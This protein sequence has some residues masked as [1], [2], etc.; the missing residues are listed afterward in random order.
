MNT[1]KSIQNFV[2][3]WLVFCWPLYGQATESTPVTPFM[4]ALVVIDIQNVYLPMMDQQEV[5]PAMEAIN[6][7]IDVFRQ[8]NYPVIRVYHHEPGQD[9]GPG[10]EAF[11]FP[12][13]V[14]VTDDDPQVIKN[15]PSAFQKT[16]LDNILKS[17]GVNSLYLCGLSATGCVLATYFGALER[18]YDVVMVKEAI[19]SNKAEYTAMVR[20]I[21][22]AWPL[23]FVRT[24]VSLLSGDMQILQT[25]SNKQ[26]VSK[27][28]IRAAADLNG[29]GY[30][31]IFKNRLA[32]AI[33]VFKANARLFPD[34]AN[35]FDSL[36]DA[37]ERNGQNELA[38]ANY[39]KAF[40]KAKEKNDP[41]LA[42]FEKNYKRLKEANK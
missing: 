38:L 21:T 10:T 32:D 2:L 18:E 36:G 20:Q 29:M 9:S 31:L 37:L 15:Y 7:L 11:A 40:L 12:R 17:K 16:E 19:M 34:E 8:S 35:C 14:S 1:A 23:S 42:V 26:L 30:Y 13:T 25:M 6:T 28:G 22:G 27:Y 41:N 39:E 3:V 4:P 33:A 5:A 24:G